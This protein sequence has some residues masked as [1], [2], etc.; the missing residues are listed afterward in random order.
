MKANKVSISHAQLV[1][2][3][4][5]AQRVGTL[6]AWCMLAV[7]WA[8]QAEEKIKE[9]MQRDMQT[10]SGFY[11][12]KVPTFRDGPPVHELESAVTA[13]ECTGYVNTIHALS[14]PV[15][16]VLYCPKCGTQHIDEADNAFIDK[17]DG[18]K[19]W[20]NPPHK[21]HLCACCSHKWRPSDTPTN[22]VQCTAS[23]K[24]ADTLP[25]I[26]ETLRRRR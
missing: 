4:A 14:K 1:E 25:L 24:D 15:D 11:E 16:M 8:R 17:G 9:L 6:D 21:T 26:S 19:A 22:G 18:I 23:G 3:L 2:L 10:V 12:A 5:H 13:E 20:G 7:D